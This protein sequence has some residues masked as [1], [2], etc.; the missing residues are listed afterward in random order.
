MKAILFLVMLPTVIV[1]WAILAASLV[2]RITH[3]PRFERFFVLT[4][5]ARTKR[6]FSVTLG[7]AIIYAPG[8]SNHTAAVDVSVE[9]H[10]HVHVR[11]AEDEAMKGL[12]VGVAVWLLSGLWWL[13]ALVWALAPALLFVHNLTGGM[14]HGMAGVYRERISDERLRAVTDCVHKWLF[15][16][17]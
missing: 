2:L 16:S 14:R 9:R 12:L 6:R 11:Q 3:R 17:N 13:G 8:H 1:S 5:E 7:R 10:E 4:A 15:D